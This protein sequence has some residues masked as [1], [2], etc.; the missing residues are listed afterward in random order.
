MW[1]S[2]LPLTVIGVTLLALLTEAAEAIPALKATAARAEVRI[3]S[4]FEVVADRRF[5]LSS[6]QI[7]ED[8]NGDFWLRKTKS[9]WSRDPRE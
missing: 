3:L 5:C 1:Y 7:Q 9:N 2:P 4:V 8:S 6:I